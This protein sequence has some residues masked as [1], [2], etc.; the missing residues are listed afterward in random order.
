M[1]SPRPFAVS[2]EI[3]MLSEAWSIKDSGCDF[4]HAMETGITERFLNSISFLLQQRQYCLHIWVVHRIAHLVPIPLLPGTILSQ[5]K[6]MPDVSLYL[7]LKIRNLGLWP[8]M[9]FFF[10]TVLFAGFFW[11]EALYA[12]STSSFI[13]FYSPHC[14]ISAL[15]HSSRYLFLKPFYWGTIDVQKVVHI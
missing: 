5:V 11:F 4:P 14:M 10:D 2:Q 3:G 7:L 1:L 12:I 15:S 8:G 13:G 6:L 9:T